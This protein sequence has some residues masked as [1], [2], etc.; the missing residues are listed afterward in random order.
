[1]TKGP[2]DGSST[3]QERPEG[4]LVDS[5]Q[6]SE[7]PDPQFRALVEA[8]E[9]YAIFRLDPGGHVVSWNAGAERIKGY[10]ADQ[11]IGEHFSTFYTET[12][13]AANVPQENLAAAA[14]QGSVTDE[15]WRVRED[16]SEF[17]ADVTITAIRNDDDELEGFAKVTRDM[18]DRK[19]AYEEHQLHLTVSHVLAETPSLSA[20]I[21][22][23]L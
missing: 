10:D 18:T 9:E 22:A 11:I 16:G 5:G 4:W 7:L 19:Q 20:G 8:V 1:M 23:A 14:E 12:D 2:E 6:R 21:Q 13:R 17:W 3:S 15:G